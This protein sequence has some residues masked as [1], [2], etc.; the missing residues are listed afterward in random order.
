VTSREFQ[1]R[2]S[3]RAKEAG[4]DIPPSLAPRLEAYFFLLAKW[5]RTIN[6]SGMPLDDP[7]REAIDRLLIEPLLASRHTSQ[8]ARM[9]DIGS[10]GGSPAIPMALAVAPT[11]LTLV[12]SR[13]RK[14]VF[15]AEAG[16]VAGVEGV[17][18]VNARY[19]AL[20]GE[21]HQ[22]ARYDL[23]TIRAVRISRNVLDSLQAFL[24]PQGTMMVFTRL[25]ASDTLEPPASLRLTARHSLSPLLGSGLLVLE[26][27]ADR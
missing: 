4:L 1:A 21:S 18:V 19:E 20:L 26:A 11:Q 6:L 10:G 7:S 2:L 14:A 16:R 22:Q 12:E 17:H 8:A 9:I 5:N 24:R 3:E 15:L 27:T 23:L 13:G 25:D